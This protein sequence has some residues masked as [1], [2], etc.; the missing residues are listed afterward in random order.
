MGGIGMTVSTYVFP[1]P[2]SSSATEKHKSENIGFDA[3]KL[4]AESSSYRYPLLLGAS[5]QHG[6]SDGRYHGE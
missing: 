3:D 1:L 5:V 6:E 4:L 2:S